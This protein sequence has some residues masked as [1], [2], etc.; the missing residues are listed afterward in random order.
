MPQCEA[1]TGKSKRCK[2]RISSDAMLAHAVYTMDGLGPHVLCENHL[3]VVRRGGLVQ[4]KDGKRWV[5]V[6]PPNWGLRL[7]PEETP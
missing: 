4:T 5:G 7:S 2:C 6:S 3:K 1:L